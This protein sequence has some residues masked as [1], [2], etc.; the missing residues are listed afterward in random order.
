[1][2]GYQGFV[3]SVGKFGM[4]RRAARNE[5]ITKHKEMW[6]NSGHGCGC[7]HHLNGDQ[8][9]EDGRV[10]ISAIRGMQDMSLNGGRN[11][12][13]NIAALSMR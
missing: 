10:M 12:L 4:D 11:T 3:S 6:M 9:K 7:H 1:M 2:K 8:L 13:T 5:A